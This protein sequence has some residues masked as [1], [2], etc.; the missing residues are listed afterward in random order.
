MCNLPPFFAYLIGISSITPRLDY[1]QGNQFDVNL[2]TID[3]LH[4]PALDGIGFQDLSA[5]LL[6]AGTTTINTINDVITQKFIGKQPAWI[7]YMTNINKAFR[8]FV[9]NEN[10]MILSRQYSINNTS[11]KDMTTYID[12]TLYN[13]I[14]ADQSFDAQNFWV[15][16]GVNI[17]ARRSLS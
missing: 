12:P 9:T 5:E 11:I 1:T 6:H 2:K 10:F 14:F 16:I 8:N 17:K 7:D 4:K 15:Q 3:D 13:G